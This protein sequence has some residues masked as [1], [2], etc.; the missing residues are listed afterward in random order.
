MRKQSPPEGVSLDALTS[1]EEAAADIKIIAL[2]LLEAAPDPI[3]VVRPGGVIALANRMAEGVFGYDRAE[4]I[5][6][7]IEM[8]VPSSEREAHV[9]RRERF[10]RKG[11]VR[12]MGE[13]AELSAVRKD[14][15]L[16]PVEVSLSPVETSLG[17]LTI[18][19]VHDIT[20]RRALDAELRYAS[21]HDALT[22]LFNRAHLEATRT[23]LEASGAAV[24]VLIA[25]VDGLKS[26]NDSLGH[27]AGDHL[28]KRAAVVLRSA[29][30][31]DDIPVRLGGDEFAL[32]IPQ[33]DETRLDEA[34]A[35]LRSEVARHNDV[36]I[37]PR[38][39]LSIGWALSTESGSIAQAMRL[40]DQRMYVDKRARR[41][42][43]AR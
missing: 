3:L 20:R 18:A 14:G 27:E 38:L 12:A 41:S 31:P 21:T 40:A 2:G 30:A 36:H 24:G 29:A 13:L 39:G 6:R 5:G 11:R 19:I 33:C 15:Q 7:P 23:R 9:Q 35:Y 34:V 4:L 22:G 17:P 32:V 25:D 1:P 8:L 26:V 10:E 16:V 42:R 43:R 37:G 28:I